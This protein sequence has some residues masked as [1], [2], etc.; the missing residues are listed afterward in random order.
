MVRLEPAAGARSSWSRFLRNALA[1]SYRRLPPHRAGRRGWRAETPAT[2][3]TTA[4]SFRLVLSS[5]F[6]TR[7]TSV[8]RPRT[9]LVRWRVSSLALVAR[10]DEARLHQPV[11]QELSDPLG[12][13]HRSCA[14]GR[15]TLGVE[16]PD[17]EAP[18]Q[19]V[20]HRLPELP[21]ALNPH[22]CSRPPSASRTGGA[23]PRWSCRR[24]GSRAAIRRRQSGRSGRPR[25]VCGHRCRAALEEHF[26]G[27]SPAPR[28]RRRGGGRGYPC[29]KALLRAP[30]GRGS[31][32]WC[33]G[34]IRVRLPFGPGAPGSHTTAVPATHA[35]GEHTPIASP[36]VR[37]RRRMP[38]SPANYR[39][40]VSRRVAG[41]LGYDAR[42][43]SA[44]RHLDPQLPQ[45]PH[46]PVHGAAG[47]VG[48]RVVGP[49]LAIRLAAGD[50]V[51][52]NDQEAVGDRHNRPARHAG[53]RRAGTARRGR[54]L[55]SAPR[56]ALPGPTRSSARRCP[57][58]ISRSAVARR[59]HCCR[60]RRPP[61]RPGG[62]ASGTRMCPGRPRRPAAP[63]SRSRSR[64]GVQELD[65]V[66]G[67]VGRA[68]LGDLRVEAR[69][70]LV[71]PVDLREQLGQQEAVV[72]LEPA[73]RAALQL[74]A[75][76]AQLAL[77]ESAST[78][79]S[80]SPSSRAARMA[81][82]ETPATLLTG[83]ELQVGAL[84][85]LLHRLTSVARPRARSWC[86]GVSSR[87][88]RWWRA[89]G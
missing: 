32:H 53:R 39:P 16:E 65:D 56:R 64:D 55:S 18:S 67:L 74:V 52:G 35:R 77:G 2:L 17:L 69:D 10:R 20:E 19:D 82:P 79:T 60:G 63:P 41:L 34:G 37:H 3:L 21:G 50:D 48:A 57:C 26:I 58:A 28:P 25:C 13:A 61:T 71:E 68:S 27:V 11:A 36:P 86:A 78:V 72:R 49:E 81:R 12:V 62:R 89:A 70:R 30:K 14:P 29:G 44:D 75:L 76:L 66:L 23:N 43:T 7:L 84:Q 47:L 80:S 8:A 38:T 31:N 45:P 33:F 59:S 5:T 1:R 22:G 87:S 15:R 88:S 85:H 73:A 4:V 54:P 42:R 46:Q 9:K 51:V 6:C 40:K 24:C 83:G